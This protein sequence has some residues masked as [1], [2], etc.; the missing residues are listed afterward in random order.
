MDQFQEIL[1]FVDAWENLISLKNLSDVTGS[2]SI[3]L[4]ENC[5]KK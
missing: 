2:Q 3:L 4:K 1:I 5:L